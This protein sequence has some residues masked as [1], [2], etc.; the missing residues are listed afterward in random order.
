VIEFQ[1]EV[2]ALERRRVDENEL[3]E[4]EKPDMR[5]LLNLNFSQSHTNSCQLLE[6]Y[7]RNRSSS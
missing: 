6:E 7:K 5:F 1:S 2:R 4:R 3:S